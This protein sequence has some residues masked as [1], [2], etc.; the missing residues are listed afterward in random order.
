MNTI[1]DV[2]EYT[3]L[4]EPFIRRCLT[5]IYI[6][7]R[8]IKRGDKNKILLDSNAISIFDN[9]KQYKEKGL[10][11]SE[12]NKQLSDSVKQTVKQSKN[13]TQTNIKTFENEQYNEVLSLTHKIHEIEKDK[14]KAEHELDLIKSNLKLLPAGGDLDK[15]K[16]MMS[17]ISKLEVL[18]RPK[19]F[20]IRSK[21]KEIDLLWGNLKELL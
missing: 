18:T 7:K 19:G 12:I 1:E 8:Y 17:L 13:Y 21:T 10:S 4:K 3:S 2:I 15:S 11:I 9:I 6:L 5:E 14:I 16:Q 20:K